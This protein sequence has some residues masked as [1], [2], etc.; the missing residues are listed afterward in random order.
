MSWNNQENIVKKD[1]KCWNRGRQKYC[2]YWQAK[3]SKLNNNV[4]G[5][6]CSLFEL[7]KK[8]YESLPICNKTYGQ[9]YDGRQKL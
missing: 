3:H 4:V 8:G 7:D 6:R 9:T 2:S 5:Y 1:G